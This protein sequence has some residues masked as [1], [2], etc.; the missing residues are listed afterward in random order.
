MKQLLIYN[1]KNFV[2]VNDNKLFSTNWIS[3][4]ITDKRYIDID[5]EQ[6]TITL[7]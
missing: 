6:L 7:L 4:Y 3:K 1:E 2:Q 5:E